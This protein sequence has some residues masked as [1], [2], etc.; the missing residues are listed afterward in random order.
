MDCV[1]LLREIL[2]LQRKVVRELRGMESRSGG[3]E[4]SVQ[5]GSWVSWGADISF[6]AKF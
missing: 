2:N 1:E 3:L 4:V 6:H 5:E